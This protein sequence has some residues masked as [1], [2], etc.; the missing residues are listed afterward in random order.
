MRYQPA[1][2][3]DGEHPRNTG[4]YRKLLHDTLDAVKWADKLID[5]VQ[6]DDVIRAVHENVSAID[7]RNPTAY[8][9]AK[10]EL[11][12]IC[13]QYGVESHD[14][15]AASLSFQHYRERYLVSVWND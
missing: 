7:Q 1:R 4:G 13:S 5:V 6:H 11:D 10:H 3:V 9:A 14:V 15:L 12:R 8:L 2:L